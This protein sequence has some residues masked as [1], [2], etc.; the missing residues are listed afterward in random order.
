MKIKILI[1]VYNDWQ[2]VFKV[3]NEINNLSIDSKFFCSAACKIILR[4]AP[5]QKFA[6]LPDIIR[7]LYL[8]SD[9]QSKPNFNISVIDPSIG[10]NSGLR[11]E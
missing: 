8:L 7:P 6:P 11:T 3:L 10:F 9:T 4:F 5:A 2:S 1:P